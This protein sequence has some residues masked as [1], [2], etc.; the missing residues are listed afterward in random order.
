MS[1]QICSTFFVQTKTP[2]TW[3][4][5]L[6]CSRHNNRDIRLVHNLT[7]GE[8]DFSRFMRLNNQLVTAPE[9]FGRGKNSSPVLTPTVSKDNDE[10]IKAAHNVIDVL[11]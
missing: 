9:N 3:M 5:N 4:L 1:R 8:A 2:T 10:H 7:R 11:D 6:K